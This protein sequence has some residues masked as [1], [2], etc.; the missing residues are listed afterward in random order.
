VILYIL[1]GL[2]IVVALVIAYVAL[3]PDAFERAWARIPGPLRT[4]INV[5]VALVVTVGGAQLVEY[6]TNA[7]IPTWIKAILVPFV[8]SGIRAINPGDGPET[9]G[10]G[11]T[12][13]GEVLPSD[14]DSSSGDEVVVNPEDLEP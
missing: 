2:A 13:P 11:K 9:G 6:L 1:L 14:G 12:V 4:W 10:Y 5:G 3:G 8:T 7:S